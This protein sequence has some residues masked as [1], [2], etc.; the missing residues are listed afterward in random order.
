MCEPVTIAMAALSIAGT[1]ASA[2]AQQKQAN[3]Q[4]AAMGKQAAAEQAALALQQDQQARASAEEMH[5]RNQVAMAEAASFDALAGEY[6]GGASASRQAA[7]L[8]FNR[9][10]DLASI[11]T[12]RDNALQQ[13]GAESRGADSR[14]NAGLASLQRP[15]RLGTALTIAG[16]AGSAY[17]PTWAANRKNEADKAR[18]QQRLWDYAN[19]HRPNRAGA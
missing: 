13:I 5:Q 7:E 14:F 15:S 4:A 2:Q 10:R 6:G 12:N 16:Q 9:D 3:A 19:E 1:V 8:A 11:K 17:A 18:E